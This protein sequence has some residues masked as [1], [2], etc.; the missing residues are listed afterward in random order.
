MMRNAML[1]VLCLSVLAAK[2]GRAVDPPAA[3]RLTLGA[4]TDPDLPKDARCGI[5]EVYTLKIST[6]KETS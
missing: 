4:C 3:P 6:L 1:A 2:A 5:Y